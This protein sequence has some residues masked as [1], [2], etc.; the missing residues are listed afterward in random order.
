MQPRK[1]AQ[2]LSPALRALFAALITLAM[3]ACG[4][5]TL[6]SAPPPEVLVAEVN[7]EDVP[8]YDDFVGT[9]EPS[10][11]ASIQ[12][13]VQGYLI[14]QNYEEGRPVKKG[15]L[16]FQISPIAFEVA[17]AQAKAALAQAQAAAKQAEMISQRNVDLFA[18][19]TISEQERDNAVLQ[20]AA[21]RANADAQAAAVRQAQVNLDYASI[22]SP[23][24]GIAGFA[25]AQVGDLVGPTTGVLTTVSTVDPI[26]A[27]FTVPD[28]RYVAY[29]ERWAGNPEGRAEH[30]RLLEFELVLANGSLYPHKGRL[31]A[32]NNDVDL[33]T[34]VQRIAT[35]FPNPGNELRGGQFARVRMRTEMRQGALLVPQRAVTDL[36]GK[37][38]VVVI[39]PDN[40]AEIRPVKPGRRIQQRWIIEEGLK[41]GERIVVEGMLKASAGTTVNPKPWTPSPASPAPATATPT[42][43]NTAAPAVTP[44]TRARNR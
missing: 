1:S 25:K 35:S 10:V 33:R 4:R 7:P 6:P 21:A 20:A 2:T 30:E 18:R 11:N 8:I 13:R 39:G 44:A 3:S 36:Q 23:I 26:K 29:I 34:G 15:D 37:Y 42:L 17:L 38:Q 41:P 22:K 24:D 19:K 27:T 14:S 31:F 43:P 28:Q 9:L 40:K 12:A 32:V 16:L 5:K